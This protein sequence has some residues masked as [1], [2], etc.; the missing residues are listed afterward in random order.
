MALDNNIESIAAATGWVAIT[1]VTNG[2]EE[3]PWPLVAWGLTTAA[4]EY[5]KQVIGLVYPSPGD[6]VVNAEHLPGFSRYEFRP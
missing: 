4:A 3:T 2:S 1:K 6:G 5:G